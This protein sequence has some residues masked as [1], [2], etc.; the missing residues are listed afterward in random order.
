MDRLKDTWRTL[1]ACSLLA[2]TTFAAFWLVF[3]NALINTDERR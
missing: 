2:A 1:R 3:D